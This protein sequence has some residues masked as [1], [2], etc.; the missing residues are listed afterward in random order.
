VLD[1]NA[2][3]A[4]SAGAW[5]QSPIFNTCRAAAEERLAPPRGSLL[6]SC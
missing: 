1:Q 3:G 6:L 5:G 4:P 2:L